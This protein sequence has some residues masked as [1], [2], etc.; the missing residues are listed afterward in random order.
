MDFL[1]DKIRVCCEKLNGWKEKKEYVVKD[2]LYAECGYKSAN[3]PKEGIIWSAFDTETPLKTGDFHYWFKFSL[4]TPPEKEGHV[5]R[6]KLT[7]YTEWFRGSANPQGIVYLNG[8]MVQGTDRNH[9][10]VPLE[11]NKNY[12]VLVYFYTNT[13]G[14]GFVSFAPFVT[15]TDTRIEKLYYDMHVPY[16]AARCLDRDDDN[17]ITI[18]KYLNNAEKLLDMRVPFSDEFYSSIEAAE[19]YLDREFYNGVCGNTD[20]S[21]KCIGHTHIDVAWLW[22]LRQTREKVQRSF[23]T[24]LALMQEYPEYK[25]MSSQPQLYQFLKEEAPEI[26]EGV[27]EMIKA[28]RWEAEGA[29][30]LEADCNLT[31]GESLV[32]QILFGK[33][34]MKEEFGVDSHV[35]WLPDVFGYSA[36]LPQILKKSGVD[37]FVTSKISWNETNKLPYDTFM[38]EGIDG[39]EIFTYFM[40]ARACGSKADNDCKTSYNGFINPEYVLGTWKRYQQ[41][42]YNKE[43]M[44]SFGFGDGGGGPTRDMLEQQRRLSYGIPGYAKTEMEFAGSFLDRVEKNLKAGA[45]ENNFMPRWVGELYLEFHRGTYTSMA[46]NKRYN[47]EFELLMRR[48]EALSVTDMLL[49]GTEYPSE[50]INDAWRTA[51][52]NQFHD[53]IPGSSIEGV[54][55]D[56][57]EQYEKILSYGRRTE[58]DMLETLAGNVNTGGGILVYNSNPFE[59]GGIIEFNGVKYYTEDIPSMGYKVVSP[60][61]NDGRITVDKKHMENK[62]FSVDF[63]DGGSMISVY[64]KINEREIVKQGGR[65]NEI[66]AFEDFPRE[67]DAWEISEYYKDKMW[68]ID[69]VS[70]VECIE[71]GARSGL[72]ITKPFLN[73]L[74]V[75]TVYLYSDIARIDF[76]TY[77]D[78]REEHILLKAAFPLD[79]HASEAAY[80]IQFGSIKR[81]THKNTSYDCAKFE[82]C[83]HKWAD[84]SED[85][86][87]VSILNNCKYGC[88]AEGSTLK[89]TLLKSA[90]YPN[91]SA[92]KEEHVFTYSLYPH[93]GSYKTGGT[94]RMGYRLNNPFTVLE[95]P[96]QSGNMPESF[97]LV[98]AD[99]ERIIIETVKKAEDDDGI[100][101]RLYDAFDRRGKVGVTFGFDFREAYVCDLM[102]NVTDKAEHDGRT[103]YINV[104]NFE[105]VTLKIVK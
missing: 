86:Y 89:L 8:N 4:H 45:E 25:F 30:W 71:D 43:V 23:S 58:R 37:K 22:R 75:Q 67:Y 87:G 80:D 51:L 92:D 12:E 56:S 35:L 103:V 90:T 105:I 31:S 40:T 73:S 7:E 42:K 28:G 18:V 27:K 66:Q 63:D 79:I 41:K 9:E 55:E 14:S 72:K 104:G 19:E 69:E 102:E 10:D 78:W 20:V 59:C 68:T 47:R 48:T 13:E 24:V 26:Y 81:P 34:F 49:F 57:K 38:W 17:Y 44:I 101:V 96:K 82:V 3:M 70:S 11:Y 64:D 98:S 93:K 95:L 32:R 16:E 2:I 46:R 39:S 74:I 52:L 61:K 36:A 83:A 62:F 6:L 5:L 54:Y 50:G 97:S 100:I 65:C 60:V 77:I 88:S 99:D 84:I 21:V 1:M 76:E 94:V 85:D 15:E 33:R 91:P 29:M 53:I